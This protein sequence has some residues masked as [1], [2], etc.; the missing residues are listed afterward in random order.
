VGP[1]GQD[2]RRPSVS[3]VFRL[4]S[5]QPRDW[6]V[7]RFC[8][9]SKVRL[10]GNFLSTHDLSAPALRFPRTNFGFEVFLQM[11]ARKIKRIFLPLQ[12]TRHMAAFKSAGNQGGQ[13]RRIDI[14]TDLALAASPPRQSIGRRSSQ[15]LSAL[16]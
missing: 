5:N 11:A 4:K 15:E 10:R 6:N 14:G 1:A 3:N 2:D 7:V 13:F 8:S 12:A 9:L 16:A